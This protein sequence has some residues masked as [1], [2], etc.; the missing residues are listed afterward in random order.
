MATLGVGQ[1][2]NASAQRTYTDCRK[3]L[4]SIHAMMRAIVTAAPGRACD[5]ADADK[6]ID[7]QAGANGS[8]VSDAKR[9]WT[10]GQSASDPNAKLYFG[11][12]AADSLMH[13]QMHNPPVIQ[14]YRACF[15]D[16]PSGLFGLVFQH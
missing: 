6:N 5:L 9:Y 16:N 14:E 11:T 15:R 3:S 12:L 2:H 1:R 10:Q 7:W 4:P 13:G 8:S